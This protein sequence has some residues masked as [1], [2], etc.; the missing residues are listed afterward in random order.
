MVRTEALEEYV[1][2]L[3]EGQKE[4]K[5]C[6]QK[7][8]SPHPAVLDELL[9]KEPGYT[10]VPVGLV[11]IPLARI[12]G[13][14]SAGRITAFTPSF[15]PLLEPNSEF[16][17]KW[18][19]L[20]ADHLGS[21]GIHDPI[22]CFEYLGNFY[23][24]EGNKR[25]SVLRHFGGSR[26]AANVKRIPPVAVD[27]LRARAYQEFLEFYRLT[28][29]YDLQFTT[30]GC[31]A[32]LLEKLE[33]SSTERWSEEQRRRFQAGYHYFTESLSSVGGSDLPQPEEALLLWLEVHPFRDLSALPSAQLKKTISQLWS[34]LVADIEPVVTT[35]PPEEKGKIK[36][37]LK[38][39][40]HVSV[41]FVHLYSPSAS[42]WTQA[43]EKGR[44]HVHNALGEAVSTCSYVCGGSQERAVEL[45]E[46]AVAEGAQ[47]IFA[48]APQLIGPCL[49]VSV[50]YPKVRFFNCSVHQPYATVQTY[51][52][53]IYEGKF[54][55]GAIA[56]A[57]CPHGRIG[58]VGS[59]PIYGV[60]ASINAF[61]LGALLT[62]P[63]AQIQLKW[64]C[65]PGKPTKEF[66]KSGIQV[67]SNR[68]TPLD[69][70]IVHEFGT[71]L[72]DGSGQLRHL[73]SPT[74]VWGQFYENV[75][76]GILK[77][78]WEEEKAGQAVNHWWGL[79]SGVID[80][81]LSPD[82]P[83]GLKVLADI[84]KK[85]ICSG[86]LDPFQRQIRDQQGRLRN[87]GSKRFTPLEL[88]TM[89]WLCDNVVG[90]FPKYEEILPMSRSTVDLLGILPKEQEDAG[91]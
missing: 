7:G 81:T 68:D 1:K 22:E 39:Y 17:S 9:Q 78:S 74:W 33:F 8:L 29:L 40:D 25:V 16:G 14:K 23:V 5:E 67:I 11:E 51:Y 83:E 72:A 52:S 44:K 45:M 36:Q 65:I 70:Y 37:F 28:G 77:G 71:Y 48:T 24:Q 26:I 75:I 55:T 12:V 85:G 64:S 18:I 66:M 50:R 10:S 73:S 3:K 21:E 27:S 79:K 30:P 53:R 15:R 54:I 56:G 76:S 35:E 80:V 61:A 58:Y 19:S 86:S 89:D 63:K 87:D 82:L 41:A 38:S 34:N 47:V 46:Q 13:T 4:Y 42:S 31:Y 62:N 59:Y 20:C 32:R 60:P 69:N 91:I 90:S 49:K 84:L 43:H 6:L 57:M 2:A 88:L